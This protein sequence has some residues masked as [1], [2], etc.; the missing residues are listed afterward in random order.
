MVCDI[1]EFT[2]LSLIYIFD[3]VYYSSTQIFLAKNLSMKKR[4]WI[5]Y[6]FFMFKNCQK[7]SPIQKEVKYRKPSYNKAA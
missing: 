3:R 5:R 6:A 4:I 1:P 7:E 2:L